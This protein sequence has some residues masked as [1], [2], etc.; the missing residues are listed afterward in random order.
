MSATTRRIALAAI[1]SGKLTEGETLVAAALVV[2]ADVSALV[3][4]TSEKD[5]DAMRAM[6][7]RIKTVSAE[8]RDGATGVEADALIEATAIADRCLA[9]LDACPTN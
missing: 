8:V 4:V 3:A 2:A 7:V 1:D 6:A 9:A 5:R